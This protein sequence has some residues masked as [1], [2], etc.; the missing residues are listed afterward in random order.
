MTETPQLEETGPQDVHC[1]HCGVAHQIAADA[2]P[3]WLCPA[4]E[5]YQDAMP[6]PYCGQTT[7]ISLLPAEMTPEP[8]KAVR[9]RKAKEE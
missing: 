8:H 6:C 7:R 3:D 9:S 2:D 4:C 1:R 5:H